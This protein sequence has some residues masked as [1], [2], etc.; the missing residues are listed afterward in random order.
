MRTPCRPTWVTLEI[1]F[2]RNP[3]IMNSTTWEA[4]QHPGQPPAPSHPESTMTKAEMRDSSIVLLEFEPALPPALKGRSDVSRLLA[5]QRDTARA[6][7]PLSGKI[8]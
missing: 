7:A 2:R 8:P 5:D 6:A 3:P 1:H 4:L